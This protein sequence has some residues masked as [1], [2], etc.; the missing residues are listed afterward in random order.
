[1]P[2]A[3]GPTYTPLSFNKLAK[4]IRRSTMALFICKSLPL[5]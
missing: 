4:A 1:L 5:V 2:A 3:Q